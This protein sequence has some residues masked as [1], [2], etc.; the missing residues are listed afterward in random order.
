[1][2]WKILCASGLAASMALAAAPANAE[3][4]TLEMHFSGE[5]HNGNHVHADGRLTIDVPIHA[6]NGFQL[7]TYDIKDFYMVISGSSLD[8]GIYTKAVQPWWYGAFPG[9]VEFTSP[10]KLDFTKELIG[11]PLSNGKHFFAEYE[12]GQPYG[13]L[14]NGAFRLIGPLLDHGYYN[15]RT[16]N[17]SDL[18]EIIRLDSLRAVGYVPPAPVPEPTTY[19]MMLAGIGLVTAAARRRSVQPS[20]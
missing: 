15:Q 8:D 10:E 4:I 3:L 17:G 6:K 18:S 5:E 19:A 2:S 20:A 13:G 9:S 14:D 1:M 12:D 11:Q 7:F 16:W